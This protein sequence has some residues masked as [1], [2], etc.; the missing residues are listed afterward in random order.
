MPASD[1]PSGGL[2]DDFKFVLIV[3]GEKVRSDKHAH[4]NDGKNREHK[5]PNH[6]L[7]M[8]E[9]PVQHAAIGAIDDDVEPGILGLVASGRR[10]LQPS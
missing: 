2:D 6:D 8:A 5:Q 10:T 1:V 3:L 7:A 9:R 4:R